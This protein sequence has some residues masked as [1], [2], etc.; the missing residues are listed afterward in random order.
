MLYDGKSFKLKL[1][2]MNKRQP[3]ICRKAV[4]NCQ[5]QFTNLPNLT[6]LETLFHVK[7]LNA[8]L[9]PDGAEGQ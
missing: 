6:N 9:K 4:F 8:D 2:F 7:F 5:M 3:K 1:P